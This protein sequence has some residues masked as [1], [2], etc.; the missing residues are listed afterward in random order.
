M[1]VTQYIG[2][3]YVPLFA[4]PILWSNDRAYE[5]L[6][7]VLYQG[8][9]FTSKQF[10]PVGID[11]TN[12]DFWA[13]TGNYNAQVEQYRQEVLTYNTRIASLEDSVPVEDFSSSN[14]VKKYI[15]DLT[16]GYTFIQDNET[17]DEAILRSIEDNVVLRVDKYTTD[18]TVHIPMN[19]RVEFGTIDYSGSAYA[20]EIT[21]GRYGSILIHK[22]VSPNGKGARL[23]AYDSFSGQ[24]LIS[25]LRIQSESSAFV[26]DTEKTII[27]CKLEGINW[28]CTDDSAL[29]IK[30]ED[31]SS[32]GQMQFSVKRFACSNSYA[33]NISA[34][35]GYLTNLD[36]GYTSLENSTH[37][38][39]FNIGES[40]SSEGIKGYFR[41]YEIDITA[42]SKVL[43]VVGNGLKL[44]DACFFQFDRYHYDKID[45]SEY[46]A[47]AWAKKYCNF[48]IIDGPCL[49]AS[50]QSLAVHGF[51]MGDVLVLDYIMPV[52]K[53]V[54]GELE[55]VPETSDYVG[56]IEITATA[57]CRITLPKSMRSG[58]VVKFVTGSYDCYIKAYNQANYYHY[59]TGTKK[60]TYVLDNN[61]SPDLVEM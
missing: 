34:E 2:A 41:V 44:Y 45:L 52:K 8:N 1:A 5:P 50:N 46:V 54:A 42:N 29:V 23:H 47:N 10:V 37:G 27:E 58:Y 30:P 43:K 51:A 40:Y 18:T 16:Q 11:I 53:N 55:L 15:D 61:G 14:T 13:L 59:T 48:I 38:I 28:V 12:E 17:I 22:I 32:V 60:L 9:S 26:C 49:N 4:N 6:T 35:T 19:A 20:V 21:D 39:L 33:I 56:L 31:G 25:I 24:C 7:V 3:R 57:D 36:F